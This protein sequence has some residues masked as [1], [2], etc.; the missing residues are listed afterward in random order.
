MSEGNIRVIGEIIGYGVNLALC[1]L[2]VVPPIV[3]FNSPKGSELKNSLAALLL[4]GLLLVAFA[5]AT[6][7]HKNA[8]G[9]MFLEKK[10]ADIRR[11][12]QSRQHDDQAAIGNKK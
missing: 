3:Y 9:K 10:I 7:L 6:V 12:A 5:A 2:I 11:E 4:F 8:V 1:G